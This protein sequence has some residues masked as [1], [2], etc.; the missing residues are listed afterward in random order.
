MQTDDYRIPAFN[1]FLVLLGYGVRIT[2]NSIFLVSKVMY[3]II[4]LNFILK[5][6]ADNLMNSHTHT[7]THTH[8]YIYMYVCVCVCIMYICI[9]IYLI[10]IPRI[11]YTTE[12]G[13]R[14]G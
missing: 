11:S 7:H 14:Y 3:L 5:K 6:L 2:K 4:Y 1:T 13:H 9:Y 12:E 10:F 8:I